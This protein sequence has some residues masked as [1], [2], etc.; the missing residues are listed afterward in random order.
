MARLARFSRQVGQLARI[1]SYSGAVVAALMFMAMTLLIL[2]EVL[3]RGTTGRSTLIASEYSGYALSAMVY[4]S[5]GY[6]FR[7]GAHI[8]IT[9][10]QDQLGAR[11]KRWLEL[12]LSLLAIGVVAFM[13][14]AVWRLVATTYRRGTVAF[15][16]AE[17]PLY[18]PQ[19]LILVGLGIFGLQLFAYA[20]ELAFLPKASAPVVASATLTETRL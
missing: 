12:L 6:G 4:L 16:P 5:L 7:E 1:C 14:P 3:L 19:A 9:F 20:L 11:A 17:T 8:R 13:L 2:F 18:L 10:V 15:T